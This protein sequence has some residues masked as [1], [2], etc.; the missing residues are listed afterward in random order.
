MEEYR[1]RNNSDTSLSL[2][3]SSALSYAEPDDDQVTVSSRD[4][5]SRPRSKISFFRS[6]GT[7]TVV[8]GM[9]SR[10]REKGTEDEWEEETVSSAPRAVSRSGTGGGLPSIQD[11]DEGVFER[12]RQQE[13][14][15]E[16]GPSTS[17][18]SLQHWRGAA[19]LREQNN[20][21]INIVGRRS[22]RSESVPESLSLS[23]SASGDDDARSIMNG[24]LALEK[25]NG[26]R[27]YYTYTTAGSSAP[28]SIDSGYDDR[29]SADDEW[30]LE[31]HRQEYQPIP[32]DRSSFDSYHYHE[33]Q[34][35][36]STSSSSSHRSPGHRSYSEPLLLRDD[37]MLDIPEELLPFITAPCAP[38]KNPTDCS[39]CGASLET[40]KYVCATCGEKEPPGLRGPSRFA[41]DVHSNGKGKG[42]QYPSPGSS[43]T[44]FAYPPSAQKQHSTISPSVS[45][46]TLVAE[47]DNPFHDSNAVNYSSH[48]K[49]LPAL[50][51]MS[52][53]SSPSSLTI[54]GMF[55][56]SSSSLS[57]QGEGY[58]LCFNCIATVGVSHAV[59]ASVGPGSSPIPDWPPSA[60][61]AQRALSQW[62]RTASRKGHTRHAY[63][64]KVWGPRGWDNVGR[65]RMP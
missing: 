26:G 37:I 1:S 14:D 2:S 9:C 35:S 65:H 63:I 22:A 48:H 29:S 31:D 56:G 50:P 19:W 61:D 59:E 41:N 46:W 45:S 51:G 39:N 38:P 24:E 7:K 3:G 58:E 33:P 53:S 12:L 34:R 43:T 57:S 6:R 52:P 30:S 25:G 18:T 20:R 11:D 8:P 13:S 47:S 4:T 42:K 32:Q 49:P 36:A 23:E 54:P 60:E 21:S 16:E 15:V 44:T 27:F 28:P 64:E 62:K 40:L 10:K 5:G 17:S 55:N